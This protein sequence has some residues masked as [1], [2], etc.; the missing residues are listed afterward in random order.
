MKLA[1]GALSHQRE[2][3]QGTIALG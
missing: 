2:N 1:K 3:S